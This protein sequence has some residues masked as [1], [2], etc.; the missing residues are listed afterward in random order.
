MRLPP[1]LSWCALLLPLALSAGC[2][3]GT[4]GELRASGTVE[5]TDAQLGFAAGGRIIWIGP[6]EGDTIRAGDVLATLDTAQA[7]ARLAQARGQLS[8]ARAQL[9]ELERGSRAEEVTQ[10]RAAAQ[11]ALRS[12]DEAQQ[13]LDRARRLADSNVVSRQ[14]LD[15][16][17]TAYDVASS[18]YDQAAAQLTLL[19]QGPRRER[20]ASQ[21]AQVE[22]AA[23]QVEAAHAALDDMLLRSAFNGLVT[24]R[25]REPGETVGAGAPVLTIIN[26]DDRW[27]RIY[28]P[29]NRIGAVRLGEPASIT[30]DTYPDQHF[31]GEVIH[32]ASEAE[33]TPRNVQTQE[34]R[35]K[36]VYA[37]KVRILSDTVM[38][39]K[40]GTPADVALQESGTGSRASGPPPARPDSHSSA[41]RP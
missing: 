21:R 26:P 15:R 36:L 9:L 8:A 17:Q 3:R 27:V 40:P 29:E 33:F 4:P 37:V 12:R 22:A 25:N 20:I 1:L 5:A 10:A 6:H 19:E 16:A 13:D 41:P 28:V 24:V 30:S 18:R 39:L 11:A 7:A 34:E 2:H 14:S 23:A 31:A 32:V 38:V 35:V